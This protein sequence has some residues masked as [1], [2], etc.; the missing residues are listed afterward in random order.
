VF[1]LQRALDVA[2]EPARLQLSIGCDGSEQAEA[3]KLL[4]HALEARGHDPDRV[5]PVG[6]FAYATGAKMI[7]REYWL[8]FWS[9]F[10]QLAPEVVPVEILPTPD[11]A[12]ID[13]SFVALHVPR[14]RRLAAAMGE[15]GMF[16]SGD[17]GPMHLASSTTVPTVALFRAS[18]AALY[19]PLKPTDLALDATRHPPATLAR[20]CHQHWQRYRA[21]PN[22]Q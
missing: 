13:P 11:T 10:L 17:T 15:M 22:L 9:S 7:A 6:F 4:R 19:G 1:L 8:K 2:H 18:E 14:P 3:R 20:F 5:H 12:P 16:I 21:R